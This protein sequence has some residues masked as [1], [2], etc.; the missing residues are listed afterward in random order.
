MSSPK[1]VTQCCCLLCILMF[2]SELWRATRFNSGSRFVLLVYAYE[3]AFNR[4][5]KGLSKCIRQKNKEMHLIT[6][7]YTNKWPYSTM[8][9]VSVTYMR[10]NTMQK[11]NGQIYQ[12]YCVS[13]CPEF[14]AQCSLPPLVVYKKALFLVP[15]SLLWICFSL[16]RW[17]VFHV[18]M[19]HFYC[20]DMQLY[21]SFEPQNVPTFLHNC[22]KS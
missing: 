15:L 3:W 11:Y 22:F 18:A 21:T 5:F 10:N 13:N 2:E 20:D 19:Y 17:V 16:D 12:L 7:C 8:I 14:V 6:F 4:K 1:F 9:V